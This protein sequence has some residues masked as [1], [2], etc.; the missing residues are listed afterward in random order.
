LRQL[1]RDDEI[2]EPSIPHVRCLAGSRQRQSMV[3]GWLPTV[4]NFAR[5]YSS[6]F[7]YAPV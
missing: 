5:Q 7:K 6:H 2:D 3:L 1:L 4:T